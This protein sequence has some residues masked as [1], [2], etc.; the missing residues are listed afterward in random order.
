MAQ[1]QQQQ[2]PMG[3][4]ILAILGIIGGVLGILG[5]CSVVAGGAL[6]GAMGAQA[7]VNEAAAGGGLLSVYGIV[8]LLIAVADIVF[9]IGA[10]TLKPWAWM[11]GLVLQGLNVVIAL[12]S[13]VAGWSTFG[14]Q[15]IGLAINAVIIYYL[16]TPDVKKA[17]GRA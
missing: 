9:G 7:G 17:F 2:R 5:G 13:I 6:I 12:V 14:S 8:I 3:I 4:T 11:L 1:Q 10:W 15:I 16:M